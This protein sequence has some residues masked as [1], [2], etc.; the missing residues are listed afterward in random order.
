MRTLAVTVLIVGLAVLAGCGQAGYDEGQR[1]FAKQQYPEAIARFT[2][3]IAWDKGRA[4]VWLARAMAY[5]K[6]KRWEDSLADC[7][8]A[9]SLDPKLSAAYVERALA[10]NILHRYDEAGADC[11]TALKLGYAGA[12]V[13]HRRGVS[14]HFRGKTDLAIADYTR[15]IDLDPRSVLSYLNRG[16]LYADQDKFEKALQDSNAGLAIE[17]GNVSLLVNAAEALI[18]LGKYPEA[19]EEC[20][21]AIAI[22]KGEE[23]AW[24]NRGE[25]RYMQA[26]SRPYSEGDSDASKP[27]HAF[28]EAIADFSEAIRLDP[29]D[30]YP[31]RGRAKVYYQLEKYDLAEKDCTQAIALDPQHLKTHYNRFA[32]RLRRDDEAGQVEDLIAVIDLAAKTGEKPPEDLGIIYYNCAVSQQTLGRTAEALKNYAEAASRECPVQAQAY[33]GR[34]TIFMALHQHAEAAENATKAIGIDS[35]YYDAYINRGI[36]YMNLKLFP[37]AIEDYRRCLEIKPDDPTAYCYR[38]CGHLMLGQVEEGKA[39]L[40]KLAA[41]NPEGQ[42][43]DYLKQYTEWAAKLEAKPQATTQ[44]QPAP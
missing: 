39:D 7:N 8:Q 1:F 23:L 30:C 26:K 29:K 16:A 25:A 17:P 37:Q 12:L 9:V 13:Y 44:T 27:D 34:C 35:S 22:D 42:L 15:A 28:D 36:C 5:G 31:Y 20:N 3:S 33:F 41:Q 18:G 32:V 4:E 14:E 21:R 11:E 40:A 10:L 6:L 19:I 2:N 43:K 38:A 24:S